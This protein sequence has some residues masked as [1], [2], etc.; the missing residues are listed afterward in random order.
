MSEPFDVFIPVAPKDAGKLPY[1]LN[2]IEK[3]LTGYNKIYVVSEQR[4]PMN[5][6]RC[7]A[8]S[9]RLVLDADLSRIG[10]RPNWIYQQFL[11]LFQNVTECDLFCTIDSDVLLNKPI[12]LF[13]DH[14]KRILYMGAEQYHQPYFTFQERLLALPRVY[15]H[16]FISDTNF[17][18][19]ALIREMLDRNGHTVGSF[20]DASCGVIRGPQGAPGACYPAEPEIWGQYAMKY[21]ADRYAPRQFTSRGLA[22]TVKAWNDNAWT[23]ADI[24][25]VI[26]EHKVA[27]TDA[28]VIH[29]WFDSDDV[30]H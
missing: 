7:V 10:Y 27:D 8:V 22:K 1:V 29:S 4:L 12:P 13:T 24:R 18:S 5:G 2:G 21:H 20:I 30:Q 23:D 25:K 19:K 11:K 26:D 17:M 16:T 14:G 15:A 28:V 9:S 6:P 3:Y